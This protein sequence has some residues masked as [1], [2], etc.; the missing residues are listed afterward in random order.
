MI[1]RN[2]L[3]LFF[4]LNIGCITS[5]NIE[6][7]ENKVISTESKK[8]SV[9]INMIA[10]Y[11]KN[12][13]SEM[14]EIIAYTKYKLEKGK[15]ESTIGNFVT[16]LCLKYTDADICIMNNGGLRTEIEKGNIRRGKIYEL[17]PFENE[18][19]IL[20]LDSIELI[21]MLQY[22]AKR[23]GEPIS[24]IRIIINESG[25]LINYSFKMPKNKEKIKILTSDYLANGGDRMSFFNNKKQE[26]LNLKVRD[27]IINYCLKNDT[28]EIQLD[29]RISIINNE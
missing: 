12:I 23:G 7:Y 16:D 11:K 29:N 18:L 19:V 22:V 1:L 20:E 9:I 13:D 28:I 8:D 14:N 2:I 24:G 26:H 17:M 4:I 6:S 27:A 10:P 21:Q 15:P 5:Y 3:Y 25:E